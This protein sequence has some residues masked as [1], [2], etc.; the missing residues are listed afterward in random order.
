MNSFV[1]DVTAEYVEFVLSNNQKKYVFVASTANLVPIYVCSSQD[2]T[3]GFRL[4]PGA[5]LELVPN[6][7]SVYFSA[8]GFV[9][10]VI[11]YSV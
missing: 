2:Y 7:Q 8:Q 4:D 6:G 3:K 9:A 1:V 11:G 10:R 5:V